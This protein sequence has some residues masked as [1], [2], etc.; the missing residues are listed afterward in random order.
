MYLFILFSVAISFI[1][2]ET[3]LEKD[4]PGHVFEDALNCS[5][6]DSRCSHQPCIRISLHSSTFVP[7]FKR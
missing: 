7:S 3:G 6:E 2:L 1:S 5:P 4:F